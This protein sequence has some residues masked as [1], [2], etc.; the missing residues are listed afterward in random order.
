MLPPVDEL[1][2]GLAR[3]AQTV[4]VL[5]VVWLDDIVND[6]PTSLST[7]LFASVVGAVVQGNALQ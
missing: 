4:G 5:Q 6:R 2:E 3:T 1:V 7:T